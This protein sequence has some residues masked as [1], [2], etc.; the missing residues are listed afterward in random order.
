M[1]EDE[2][3]RNQGSRKDHRGAQKPGGIGEEL[4]AALRD[5][6]F[7]HCNDE[8]AE[9]IASANERRENGRKNSDREI[10]EI[11]R[12]RKKS[13]EESLGKVRGRGI[14]F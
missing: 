6:D 7:R 11:D 8:V 1:G 2:E 9:R 14:H 12:E 5:V 10:V 3:Y 4:E 13:T